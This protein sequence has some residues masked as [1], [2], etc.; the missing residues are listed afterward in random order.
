MEGIQPTFNMADTGRYGDC[1]GGGSGVWFIAI[2]AHMLWGGNGLG[3]RDGGR[4]ATTEDV[5]NSANFTRLESQVNANASAI[6]RAKDVIGNGI[7]DL[8]YE[9]A[10]QF[11][12]TN[13]LVQTG[14]C[15]LSKEIL[16][17]RYLNEKAINEASAKILAQ[18]NQNK[19]EALQARINQLEL[20]QAVNGVVRYPMQTVFASTCNPFCH[21]TTTTGGT[22]TTTA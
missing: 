22:T 3:N 15:N 4:Y 16:E 18:L 11:G 6:D 13:M 12:Q 17:S 20:A 8:G 9:T 7:A 2:L 10:K 5:N 1:L 21:T 19:V 14:N